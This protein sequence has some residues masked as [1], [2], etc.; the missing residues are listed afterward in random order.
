M[1]LS[2]ATAVIIFGTSIPTIYSLG[3]SRSELG[4]VGFKSYPASRRRAEDDAIAAQQCI[5]E[6]IKMETEDETF[7]EIFN[8]F[9]AI[10]ANICPGLNQYISETG[11]WVQTYDD[12]LC[13]DMFAHIE[14]CESNPNYQTMKVPNVRLDCFSV[15]FGIQYSTYAYD[16]WHCLGMSCPSDPSEWDIQNFNI[17]LAG[18]DEC[19]VELLEEGEE[20]PLEMV[21]AAPPETLSQQCQDEIDILST[22]PDLSQAQAVL[23]ECAPDTADTTYQLSNDNFISLDDFRDCDYISNYTSFCESMGYQSVVLPNYVITCDSLNI[24]VPTWGRPQC[25]PMSCPSTS[26]DWLASDIHYKQSWAAGCK[27]TLME[28]GYEPPPPSLPTTADDADSPPSS[29]GDNNGEDK[30]DLI[31]TEEVEV[32][33][34][35]ED[36]NETSNAAISSRGV[37]ASSV[38]SLL[39]AAVIVAAP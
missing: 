35:V 16:T 32:E 12:R 27:L 31:D 38:I 7:V 21:T 34:E 36:E 23:E 26:A 37:V 9:A 29:E 24:V 5:D 8:G 14:Y 4:A 1:K 11:G 3:I 30:I 25:V 22:D 18:G 19:T 28:E 15:E 6:I 20:P 13:P 33:D 17:L 2:L 39:L 10:R